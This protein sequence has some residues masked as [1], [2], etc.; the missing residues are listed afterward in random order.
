[1]RVQPPEFFGE[2]TESEAFKKSLYKGYVYTGIY[3]YTGWNLRRPLF[4]DVRVRRA[5]AMAFDMDALIRT[6]YHGL[7]KRVTGP[8]N[9]FS[10]NYDHSIPP[11]PYDP[12]RAE[13]LLA[14]AGWYDR[15]GD[16]II[17]KDGRP[18]EF[19]F[20]YP[21]GNESSEA[22]GLRYQEALADLG[23]KMTMA[24]LEWATMRERVL[25]RDFDAINLA[26]VPELESDPEQLWH[27][28]WGAVGKRSSN[29]AGWQDE[30]TDRLIALI[31]RELDREKRIELWKAFHARIADQQPY[32]FM[33]NP[34]RGFAVNRSL[35]GFQGFLIPPGY[36]VRRLHYPEGTPGTRATPER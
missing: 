3:G 2:A 31:Q 10:I 5:L 17:D 14:E 18:F 22:F 36:S 25:E 26:W 11:M 32:L 9:Y 13:E 27:S 12:E 19:E 8:G 16:G 15:D 21:G 4:R 30:E 35:R 20:L 29:H 1:M 24:T 23:I 33:V 34:P 28:K 7:A 6:R